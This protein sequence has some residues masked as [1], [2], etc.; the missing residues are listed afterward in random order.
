MA[1]RSRNVL[2]IMVFVRIINCAYLWS[3]LLSATCSLTVPP[4]VLSPSDCP[5]NIVT[6][7]LGSQPIQ[8]FVAGQQLRNMQQVL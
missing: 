6:C 7:Y 1:S 4:S 5:I 3:V 2:S 8:R